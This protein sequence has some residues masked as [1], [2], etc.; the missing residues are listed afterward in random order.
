MILPKAHTLDTTDVC[1]NYHN[2]AVLML[3]CIP[4]SG[5][6]FPGTIFRKNHLSTYSQRKIFR[7]FL[8]LTIISLIKNNFHRLMFHKFFKTMK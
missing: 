8:L 5:A 3:H 1:M 2:V 7:V 4:Y 6:Y